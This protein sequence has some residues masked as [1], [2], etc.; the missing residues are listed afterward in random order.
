[1]AI[2]IDAHALAWHLDAKLKHKL[3][4]KASAAIEDAIQNS[5]IYVPAIALMEIMH[6]GEK[7]RIEVDFREMIRKLE[8]NP[9]YE[10]VPLDTAIMKAAL[11]LQGLEMHDRIISAT[12]IVTGSA[13]V[14]K[15]SEIKEKI[16]VIW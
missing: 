13:L 4:A 2:T 8:T 16:T 15:D 6:I 9:A 11:E 5:V 7:K 3:S 10:I 1:M 14:S 12:A